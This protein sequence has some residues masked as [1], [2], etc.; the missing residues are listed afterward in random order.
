MPAPQSVAEDTTLPI[1]GLSVADVD[2]TVLTTT[3]TVASGTLTIPLRGGGLI[4]GSGTN[5][6]VINTTSAGSST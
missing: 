5:S 6:L 1:P 2:G 4:T 3:L